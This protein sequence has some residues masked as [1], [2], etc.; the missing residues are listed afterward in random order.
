MSKVTAELERESPGAI[1][2]KIGGIRVVRIEANPRFN[3]GG[4]RRPIKQAVRVV[5]LHINEKFR[6]EW[7]SS[8]SMGVDEC[9]NLLQDMGFTFYE[10]EKSLVA[11]GWKAELEHVR[12]QTVMF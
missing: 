7:A 11:E 3:S 2:V 6:E 8:M 10:V 9:E 5:M 12:S 1:F 4:A